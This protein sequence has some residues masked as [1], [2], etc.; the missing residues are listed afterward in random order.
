M[1]VVYQVCGDDQ[2]TSGVVF[3]ER[4]LAVDSIIFSSRKLPN[5]DRENFQVRREGAIT[6]ITTPAGLHYEIR[7]LNVATEIEHI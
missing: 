5:H 2:W 3:E 6:H 7:P 4:Q 1:Q